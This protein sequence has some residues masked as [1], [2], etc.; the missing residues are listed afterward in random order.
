M[1]AMIIGI[2]FLCSILLSLLGSAV[3]K[4]PTLLD[5][6]REKELVASHHL[7]EGTHEDIEMTAQEPPSGANAEEN[8]ILDPSLSGDSVAIVSKPNDFTDGSPESPEIVSIASRPDTQDIG[9]TGS[10]GQ[11]KEEIEFLKWLKDGNR[12]VGEIGESPA[13]PRPY[14]FH[15]MNIIGI[16]RAKARGEP[17]WAASAGGPATV[18]PPETIYL[19]AVQMKILKRYQQE[20]K[21]N[22]I[23][24]NAKKELSLEEER[25]NSSS[26]SLAFAIT[27]LIVGLLFYAYKYDDEGTI[28]PD[29]TE[30]LG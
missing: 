1:S 10:E 27:N 17:Y 8:L 4:L 18:P 13:N 14:G 19:S 11:K 21:I 2:V 29:W 25:D 23:P 16:E 15:P 5:R 26:I 7:S 3:K 30:W 6:S 20:N 24:E 28:K 9:Y 22:W 12:T